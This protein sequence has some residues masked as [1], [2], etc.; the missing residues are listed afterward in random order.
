MV[1]FTAVIKKF[2]KQGE[3]TGWTYI[4]VPEK[5]SS[6]LKEGRR[7]SFRVKGKLDD[8][9]INGA[10]LLPMGNGNF[11]LTLNAAIRKALRK[12]QGDTV[13]VKLE[14]DKKELKP[15]ADLMLCMKDEQ[16]ALQFFESL[17]KG[18]Q[19]YFGKWIDSAKTESTRAKRIAHT[20][21]AMLA[22][23]DYGSMIRSLQTEKP[24]L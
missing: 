5:I 14:E 6:A 1:T 4:D 20:I 3:K 2:A 24:R 19:N 12:K 17:T 7:Q 8:V 22:K 21:N 11:I 23:R 10:A 15:P 16:D 13:Q 18:H 9:A